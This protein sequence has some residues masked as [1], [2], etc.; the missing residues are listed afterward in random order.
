MA[1]LEKLRMVTQNDDIIEEEIQ[2][3][4][5]QDP[6]PGEKP[7]TRRRTTRTATTTTP[8]VTSTKLAKQVAA[9][10]ASLIEGG[11]VIWGLKDQCC[12]PVL[13]DQSRDIADA[14]TAILARN[15][16]LLAKFAQTDLAV[17]TVQILALT[18]AVA[19]VAKAVYTNHVSK[20][21]SGE[22]DDD[23]GLDIDQF[24]TFSNNGNYPA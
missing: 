1:L 12:A 15:P 16:A 17:L 13:A 10:L 21:A 18:R 20:P 11:A 5:P 22:G 3:E 19:P 14:L 6:V 2:T 7:T 9:D 23:A 24:P 4:L 8:K